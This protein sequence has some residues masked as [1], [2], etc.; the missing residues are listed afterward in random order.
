M[1]QSRVY[2]SHLDLLDACDRGSVLAGS[3]WHKNVLVAKSSGF[4]ESL[5]KVRDSADLAPESYLANR[6]CGGG[7]RA[8]VMCA[9]DR[10][11]ERKVGGGLRDP[12]PSHAGCEDVAISKPEPGVLFEH[13]YQHREAIGIEPGALALGRG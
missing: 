2:V 11:E 9:G 6:E 8:F 3:T 10:K 7:Q 4:Q 12:E 13:G 1:L 5:L